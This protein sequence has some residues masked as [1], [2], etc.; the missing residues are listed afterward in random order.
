VVEDRDN[1]SIPAATPLPFLEDPAGSGFFTSNV[2]LGAIE[3]SSDTD[4]WSF[5]ARAGDRASFDL[6]RTSGGDG[7]RVIIYNA[8]GQA[9]VDTFSSYSWFGSPPKTSY[10]AFTIPADGTYYARILNWPNFGGN[11]AYQFRIDLGRSVQLESYDW[12]QA[13]D[14]IS[15]ANG[16]SFAAGAPGHAVDGSTRATA[17]TCPVVCPASAL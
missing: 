11:W 2:A 12:N 17:S 8:A 15:G 14:S 13:N 10:P 3:P 7:Q 1:D 6:E 5:A 9:I 4:Y 16:L